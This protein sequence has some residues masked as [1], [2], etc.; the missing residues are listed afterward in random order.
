MAVKVNKKG[1]EEKVEVPEQP[2]EQ[3]EEEEI[4]DEV[5]EDEEMETISKKAE[6]EIV[7]AST[8]VKEAANLLSEKENPQKLVE[9]QMVNTKAIEP[10]IYNP[11]EMPLE[12]FNMLAGDV[13]EIG[14]DQPIVVRKHPDIEG[15]YIIIDGEHRWRSAMSAGIPEI[16]IV[17]RDMDEDEAQIVTVRRNMLRGHLNPER[18]TKVVRG[19]VGKKDMNLD[20][21]RKK[22]AFNVTK[23]FNKVYRGQTT[24]AKE[25]VEAVEQ[26]KEE[27]LEISTIAANLSTAVRDIMLNHGETMMDG[28]IYFMYKGKKYLMLSM[29]TDFRKQIEEL[30]AITHDEGIDNAQ[31]SELISEV[32]QQVIDKLKT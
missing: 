14:I 22:M 5:A 13:N 3:P 31:L 2:E 25:A 12:T 26:K 28:Y 21:V 8:P 11:N 7:S 9:F 19:L 6:P 17:V 1:D 27:S 4:P 18:F 29:G 15:R 30:I 10:N 16:P 23:E 24:E 32:T 20:D